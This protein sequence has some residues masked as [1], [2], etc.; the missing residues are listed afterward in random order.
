MPHDPRRFAANMEKAAQ[1]WPEILAALAEYSQPPGPAE[2][3]VA[4]HIA[5]AFLKYQHSLMQQQPGDLMEWQLNWW[6]RSSELWQRQWR[7]FLGG[8]EPQENP[9]KDRRFKSDLWDK[10]WF[11]E[12]LKKHYL[13]NTE[14]LQET[15][16]KTDDDLDPHTAHLVHFYSKQ[17][18]DA[19]SPGNFP[20]SNPEVLARTLESDGENLVNGMQNLLADLRAGRISMTDA[21]A[22]ELGKNIAATP[23]KVVF[24]NE[25]LQ[26]IQYEPTTKEVRQ[27]PLLVIPAW[28]NKYYILDLQPDN[29]M[30]KWLVGKGFTVFAVSWVNPDERHREMGFDDYLVK[31]AYAALTAVEQATGER[32]VHLAGYCLGGTLSACLLSWLQAKGEADRVK[33]ATFLTT[34]VDFSEAGDLKVFIDEPQ[35]A[36]MEE[37]MAAKGY[38]DGRDMAVTFN[39]LRPVDLIW[40]FVINNYLLGKSP[41]PF[42]L[43]YW[44][45][46]AT[47]MPAKMHR[48][49]LREMYLKNH[50][51]QPGKLVLAGEKMDLT[52]ITTPSYLLSTKEDHI[53]PWTSAYLA[54]QQYR[55]EVVFVLAESGH[56]AGVIN[57]PD[58]PGKYGYFLNPAKPPKP[59]DWMRGAVRQEGS[60]WPHW[61]AWVSE[62]SS[63]KKAKARKPGDG[64]LK[65]IEPAPGRYARVK[66]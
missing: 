28:I 16:R 55:G 15:L 24:E 66:S 53:A 27:E 13:L 47:R 51:A 36:A 25:L 65:V 61:E 42:D 7:Q 46:D 37:K 60:W 45:M 63:G 19:L 41:F 14:M 38:L 11:F 31:G 10:S 9:N 56:I 29:S 21:T 64:K 57:S 12:N 35:I 2:Q 40:S 59:Q 6:R 5:E 22:F 20:W 8:N 26:L 1:L 30:V 4:A 17:W 23:G 50:L 18:M 34:L 58:R 54:T 62:N 49:Y 52:R 32:A 44:N 33:T 43:L 39:L 48:T 3:R